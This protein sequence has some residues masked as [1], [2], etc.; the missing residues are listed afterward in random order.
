MGS[1][2]NW[3]ERQMVRRNESLRNPVLGV[4]SYFKCYSFRKGARLIA[5]TLFVQAKGDQGQS[6]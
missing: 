5:E 3:T 4:R 6:G 1:M 2:L